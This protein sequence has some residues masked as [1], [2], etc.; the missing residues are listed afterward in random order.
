MTTSGEAASVIRDLAIATTEPRILQRGHIY[1][2]QQPGGDVA[3]TDLTG[4]AYRDYPQHKTGTVGV[5]DVASFAQYWAK[6]HDDASE[7]FADLDAATITA[8]LDAHAGDGAR[9]QR[10]RLTLTMRKTPQWETWTRQDRKLMRQQEFAEFLEDNSGDIAADE[11]SPV[12]AADL[13]ELAQEFHAHTAVRFSSGKRLQSGQTQLVYSETIE[14]HGGPQRGTI[15]IPDAFHLGLAPL[16]DST[17][18]RV[19][20]RFRY[21]LTDGE[22]RLG[23]HLDDPAGL[24]RDAVSEVVK[25]AAQASGVK[26]MR[27]APA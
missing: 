17:P 23:F 9:W 19:K 1:G 10:H 16:E 21:R 7:V 13:I 20:A 27:G 6:H 8:V 24:F 12:K 25:K 3:V 18:Y 22:L 4:D 14:A 26:I 15:A 5:R 2:W 11:Q